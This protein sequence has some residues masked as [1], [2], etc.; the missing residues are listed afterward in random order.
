MV[1]VESALR[2]LESFEREHA[3]ELD[4][5]QTKR[6][7]KLREAVSAV[8]RNGRAAPPPLEQEISRESAVA[9]RAKLIQATLAIV[10]ATRNWTDADRSVLEAIETLGRLRASEATETLAP[11]V[12]SAIEA[13]EDGKSNLEMYPVAHALSKI[14]LPAVDPMLQQVIQ[15]DEPEAT[16]D[17]V[18]R[19]L[20]D[21]MPPEVAVTFVD[22]AIASQK[23]ELAKQRLVDLREALN[24]LAEELKEKREKK[25]QP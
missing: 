4:A 17:V 10:R 20:A 15:G 16:R 18:A 19:V 23:N 25:D 12:L 8:V 24:K 14:G 1:P 3:D 9:Q 6:I 5:E 2:S 11:H 22:A 21:M 7:Q 13:E